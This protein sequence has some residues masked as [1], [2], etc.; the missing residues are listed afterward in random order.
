MYK[1]SVTIELAKV[2]G[3][4]VIAPTILLEKMKLPMYFSTITQQICNSNGDLATKIKPSINRIA[5]IVNF[6]THAQSTL[7]AKA[8]LNEVI[9]E[10]SANL[11]SISKFLVEQKKHNRQQ[12]IKRLKLA[13]EKFK[14]CP[15]PKINKQTND[16]ILNSTSYMALIA[17]NAIEVN[18]LN[19]QIKRLDYELNATNTHPVLIVSSVYAPEVPSNKEPLFILG[20]CLSLGLIFGW[21][22][23]G[24]TLVAPDIWK[25]MREAESKAN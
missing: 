15:V 25:Q 24:L 20:I 6:V 9:A 2:A 21:F 11:D 3:H 10:I 14:N 22:M 1:A 19:D 12:L 23:T 4:P 7:E 5:P 17:A 16:Q 8:C 13:E 18:A